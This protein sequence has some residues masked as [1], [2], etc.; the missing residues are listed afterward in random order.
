MFEVGVER[1]EGDSMKNYMY[2]DSLY[3]II[4]YLLEEMDKEGKDWSAEI[5]EL[6][7]AMAVFDG[8]ERVIET[9]KKILDFYDRICPD[10][11]REK[12]LAITKLEESFLWLEQAMNK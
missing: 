9:K 11:S 10:S 6:R 12:S 5:E 1:E 3:T 2:A 7:A 4:V 8:K